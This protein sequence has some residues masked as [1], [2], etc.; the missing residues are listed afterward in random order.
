MLYLVNADIYYSQHRPDRRRPVHHGWPNAPDRATGYLQEAW[1][2]GRWQGSRQGSYAGQE[3]SHD[4]PDRRGS[5]TF[6]SSFK[7]VSRSHTDT[8]KA[9]DVESNSEYLATVGIG[10]PAQNLNLDFD[11]G[12]ADLWVWSTELP[13]AT[14][15]SGTTGTTKHTI[16]NPSKSSTW[17]KVSADTWQ[18]Q[19][20]DGSTASGDV[21]T[22]NLAIG[23]LTVKNQA[24][25]LAKTL[26]SSFAQGP[27]DGLL[28]LAWVNLTMS[29]RQ[30]SSN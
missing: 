4:R 9:Q 2:E 8:S 7:R 6:A 26:S 1:Q 11:T 30:L 12:S 14:Q 18:I 13:A 22:D 3:G 10:T 29:M 15:K 17:K 16:F 27:G 23:G 20:G 5:G 28:G 24:I 25:E 21:G 19:Y